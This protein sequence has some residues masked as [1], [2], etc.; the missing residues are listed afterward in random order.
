MQNTTQKLRP[1]YFIVV[2]WGDEFLD[3]LTTYCIPS[4]LA[5]NN[6]PALSNR[7]K[8]LFC[9]TT[10]DWHKLQTSAS[11]V[12]LCK[13]VDPVFLEIP[14]PSPKIS[15]YKAMGQGH[16]L[17]TELCVQ[18]KAYG[19]A[20]T[21]DLILSDGS[22]KKV[23][24]LALAGYE[25]VLCAALRFSQEKVFAH[26]AE[27]NIP[28]AQQLTLTGRQMVK[29]CMSS[30]HT[31][32]LT[33]NFESDFYA[34]Y[35]SATYFNVPWDGGMLVHSLSWAPMLLDYSMVANHDI[36]CL[37]DWTM[38]GDYVCKNFNESEKIYVCQDSDEMMLISWGPDYPFNMFAQ[39]TEFLQRMHGL[40]REEINSIT[41][42]LTWQNPLFDSLKRRIFE[43][44]VR[45]HIKD[46]CDKWQALEEQA[47]L[48]LQKSLQDN[49][50]AEV[51]RSVFLFHTSEIFAL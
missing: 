2:V 3:Y 41:L 15:K 21:P 50:S 30:L 27:L 33:Y 9:T 48:R 13:Y 7:N 49:Y 25:V 51:K 8:F 19:I 24:E 5:P 28:G 35:S 45:W 26:L 4:L 17:A 6:I 11:Y 14:T 16:I 40:P 31:E 12:E 23:E 1:F 39:S 18:D 36:D 22:L 46:L 37:R 47:M 38:D 44:P 42:G 34:L 10:E 29:I 20:L 32:T 43:L